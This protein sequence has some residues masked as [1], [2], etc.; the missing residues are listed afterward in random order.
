MSEHN[1][2]NFVNSDLLSQELLIKYLQQCYRKSKCRKI[3]TEELS[4]S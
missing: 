3:H 4:V 2:Q 1:S